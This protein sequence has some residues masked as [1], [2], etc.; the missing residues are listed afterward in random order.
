MNLL[1]V[2][3][4][5]DYLFLG[6][7]IILHTA[8]YINL[9]CVVSIPLHI[10]NKSEKEEIPWIHVMML[11]ILIIKCFIKEAES[12]RSAFNP[13]LVYLAPPRFC[14]CHSLL[15]CPPYFSLFHMFF[16]FYHCTHA[17]FVGSFSPFCSL[18]REYS[19]VYVL[20]IVWWFTRPLITKKTRKQM[21]VDTVYI[22]G[23]YLKSFI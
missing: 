16:P 13:F 4:N 11:N 1:A 23:W 10:N 22:F 20:A 2:C 18:I 21:K 6:L 14:F 17:A 12:S 19:G 9:S 15:V 3:I 5:S 8:N 7:K